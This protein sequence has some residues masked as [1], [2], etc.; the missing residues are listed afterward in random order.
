[1]NHIWEGEIRYSQLSDDRTTFPTEL[2]CSSFYIQSVVCITVRHELQANHH[3]IIYNTEG[4]FKMNHLKKLNDK[5]QSFE[6]FT[7]IPW[8]LS[9]VVVFIVLW[10]WLSACVSLY[11]YVQYFI[12]DWLWRGRDCILKHLYGV[13][14]AGGWKATVL[15]CNKRMSDKKQR[16]GKPFK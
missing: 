12:E 11:L 8:V 2:H 6:P 4:C 15:Q 9:A 14:V 13:S 3:R 7:N 5:T 10:S 1:M 16:K